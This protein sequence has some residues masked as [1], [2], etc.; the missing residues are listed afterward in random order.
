MGYY[1]S[2]PQ[3]VRA[4]Q[5]TGKNWGV[6]RNWFE[7]LNFGSAKILPSLAPSLRGDKTLRLQTEIMDGDIAVGDWII[8]NTNG[9]VFMA[10]DE[11]F[12][13]R[14]TPVDDVLDPEG[15]SIENPLGD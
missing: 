6:L 10:N 11:A 9:V 8:C 15:G 5:W 2:K 12:Q 4:M 14:Y 13:E 3:T 7:C 1:R